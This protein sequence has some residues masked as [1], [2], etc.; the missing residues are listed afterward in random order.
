MNKDVLRENIIKVDPSAEE[1]FKREDAKNAELAK[2]R[3]GG[4]GAVSGV[5]SV[6]LM[7]AGGGLTTCGI[8]CD[9]DARFIIPGVLCFI[10]A[11]VCIVISN[12][13]KSKEREK[14]EQ[15]YK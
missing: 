2:T 8:V 13:L 14:I 1:T 3:W 10:A 7:L 11:I 5:L 9:F 15:K 12:K 4:K 6:I